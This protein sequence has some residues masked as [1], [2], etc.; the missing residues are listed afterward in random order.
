M[1][2]IQ[3]YFEPKTLNEATALLADNPDLKVIAGG[4]DLL[5]KMHHGKIA[6]VK[7]L[8]IRKIKPLEGV[9]KLGD[10]T[11]VIGALTT[12]TQI[13][14]APVI[15]ENIPILKEAALSVGG[16]QIRNV[17]TI[18]G[19]I[20]NGVTSADSA[21]SLFALNARL[22]LVSKQE[23]RVVPIKEF[24]LGPGKVDLRPRE[25]L[26]EIII[27]PEDYVGYGGHYIK[28]SM[29]KAMDIAT[30]GVATLCKIKDGNIFTSVRIAL[31]VAA[32]TPIRCK[33]AEN[34][35]QGKV[36]SSKTLAEIARLAVK[37]TKARSSWRASREY[38]EHLVEELS[39][40]A[41][42]KAIISAGGTEI[43]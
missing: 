29:R 2:N 23:E 15:T 20:C 13:I 14:N 19:N 21:S 3:A 43:A 32:P 1:Y 39:Q 22:K 8:S 18:G 6:E 26:A 36:I 30:L 33:E 27:V 12:F 42:K 7:L 31:G 34:Y 11:I 40:R 28:F 25:I 9:C 5:I 10:G 16:P 37:S 24:Y 4:T 41:L 38:R 35:A 17:A